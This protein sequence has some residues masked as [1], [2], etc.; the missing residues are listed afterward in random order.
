MVSETSIVYPTC[1]HAR[2]SPPL[3]IPLHGL[4]IVGPP[5]DIHNHR[6]YH[7]PGKPFTVIIEELKTSLAEAL[8]LYPPV[9]GTVKTKGNGVYFI[10]T[11]AVGTP[12]TVEVLDTPYIGDF[13]GLSARTTL[14]ELSP[15]LAV[16]VSQVT[17]LLY[18]WYNF[19][20]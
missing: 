12:F 15:S 17:V 4:D 13:E 14:P 3:V 18:F 20:F 10:S 7:S 8:E 11:E 9:A 5:M 2:P 6:F 16:K 19:Y 1:K